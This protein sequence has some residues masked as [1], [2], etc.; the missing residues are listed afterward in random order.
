MGLHMLHYHDDL[1]RDIGEI[2]RRKTGIFA[3]FKEVL[4]P[5]Q[6]SDY[7]KVVAGGLH[8]N[9]VGVSLSPKR[10]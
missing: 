4:A 3:P 8:P 5:Y 1:L 2:P 9:L 10:A 6:P 7:G